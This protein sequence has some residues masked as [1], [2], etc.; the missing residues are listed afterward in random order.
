M[1]FGG[2]E[3]FHI[4]EGWLHKGLKLLIEEDEKLVDEYAADWLGVG[5]NM[6]KSI[7]HWLLATSLA[8]SG[9]KLNGKTKLLAP[10]ELGK[11]V[12]KYDP[13]FLEQGTWWILHVNLVNSKEHALTWSWFF[14]NYNLPNFERPSCID[15]LMRYVE[16]AKGQ[17]S[18]IKTIQRDIACLLNTYATTLP[19]EVIDPEE[20]M[21]CPFIEL[22]LMRYFKTSGR[23]QLNYGIKPI[24]AEVFCYNMA[25]TFPGL[26]NNAVPFREIASSAG[27]PGRCFVLSNDALFDLISTYDSQEGGP[28]INIGNV[29]GDRH[30]GFEAHSKDEWVSM[31][32]SSIERE[33]DHAA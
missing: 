25:L 1:R 22:D 11:L 16:Q 30:I 15:A 21:E 12:Y 24:P 29:A 17:T 9:E 14:N 26:D 19:R 28:N 4:R 18:S 33:L 5:K 32:F 27:G 2:H 8:E 6:A 31:Y 20:A 13:Y 10:T 3:T 7:R 23:Y